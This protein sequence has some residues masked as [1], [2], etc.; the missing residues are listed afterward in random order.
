M[1]DGYTVM[2]DTCVYSLFLS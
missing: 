2:F 1:S